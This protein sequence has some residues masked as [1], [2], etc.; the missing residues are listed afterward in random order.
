MPESART[1]AAHAAAE[2]A[3]DK[4]YKSR[5]AGHVTAIDVRR[6]E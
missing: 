3:R 4:T 2:M 5:S 6:C 1:E